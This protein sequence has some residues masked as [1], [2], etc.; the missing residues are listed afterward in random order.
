MS[1]ALVIGGTRSGK[2]A[3]AERLA[4]ATGGKVRYIATADSGDRSMADR[5]G[6]HRDRRPGGWETVEVGD[7]LADAID[8][9]CVSLIDGLG[10][11]IAGV[12]HRNGI[13]VMAE[14]D[15]VIETARGSDVIVVAEEA[16]QGLL[17]L[18]T[19]SREWL[20]QLGD[21]IQRVSAAADRVD[22]VVAGRPIVL[23]GRPSPS[24]EELR[25]HGDRDPRLGGADHAVNVIAGGPPPWLRAALQV[26]LD[27]GSDRH[28]DEAQARAVT[29]GRHDRDPSEVVVTN[30]AAEAL[31][32]LGPALRPRLAVCVHPGFTE[33]E[34]ALNAHGIAV[35][36]V[37]RDPGAGFALDPRAVPDAA[38]LV[39]VGN[40]ASAS[41]TLD[42]AAAILALRAPRR[43][44][45]VDEAFMEMVP[46]EP[47][48][49]AGERLDDLIVIRSLTGL[50]SVPGLRVG[51]ALAPPRL[52]AA[53]EAVR[54][55]WS[56]NVLALAA[57]VAAAAHPA[58]LAA[59]AE[60][61]ASQGADLA[62]RLD[63]IDGIRRW[64]SATNFCLIEVS[65]G[66]AVLAKLLAQ[67]I[68]VCPASF[69]GLGPG[70]L[71]ITARDPERNARAA[72]AIGEA[73]G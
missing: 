53:L 64:Q 2:S 66:P 3:H 49:L 73:L 55:P 63:A 9:E 71:R 50:L 24:V 8:P 15:R 56:A 34:A 48:S 58:E 60:Q 54:P 28:F 44:V 20:D 30:G 4:L 25:Q 5:I 32:L 67:Q 72:A 21:A 26:A 40:P 16:G 46:G 42:P 57:L 1:L 41:G 47:G 13:R 6:R 23:A 51:Y 52:A 37:Q 35:A 43:V 65:D 61:A 38:D 11:W 7:S 27:D 29:A 62:R 59:R 45:V 39:I 36:R 14:I 10:V 22:Y 68:A 69:P 17:P 19:V 33:A 12:L 70:H 31:W 18:D